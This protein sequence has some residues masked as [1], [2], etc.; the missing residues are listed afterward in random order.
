MSR[1]L[2]YSKMMVWYLLLTDRSYSYYKLKVNLFKCKI[3]KNKK[4]KRLQ[5][6]SRILF[7]A[8]SQKIWIRRSSMRECFI[9]KSVK[10]RFTRCT[11][12]IKS[13]FSYS[14][15]RWVWNLRCKNILLHFHRHRLCWMR[16]HYYVHSLG[17]CLYFKAEIRFIFNVRTL[18][19]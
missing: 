9:L 10:Y 11:L 3:L 7:S 1:L 6:L 15:G 14:R 12:F 16:L 2:A 17:I 18:S 13:W 19:E 4:T 5:I 8:A